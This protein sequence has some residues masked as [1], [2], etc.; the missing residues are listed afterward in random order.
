MYSA[1]TFN[2]A[3]AVRNMSTGALYREGL[4]ITFIHKRSA[5]ALAARLNSK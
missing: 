2:G 3:W 1:Y 4:V 5:D